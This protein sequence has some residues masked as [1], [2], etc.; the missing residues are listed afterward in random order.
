MNAFRYFNDALSLFNFY[1]DDFT[2][3]NF[4]L[5]VFFSSLNSFWMSQ[6]FDWYNKLL[7]VLIVN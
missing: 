2:M 6:S 1:K 3:H 5:L 4:F 7:Q